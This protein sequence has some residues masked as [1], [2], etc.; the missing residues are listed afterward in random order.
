MGVQ[1]SSHTKRT[2]SGDL[3]DDKCILNMN[4]PVLSSNAIKG[5]FLELYSEQNIFFL[6]VMNIL[7]I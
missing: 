6:N 1:I 3:Q 5:L 2:F 4:T 7:I